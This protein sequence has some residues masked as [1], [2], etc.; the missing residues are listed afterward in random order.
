MKIAGDAFA[1]VL[2]DRYLRKDLFPLQLHV[3]PVVPD[4]GYEEINDN[5][6]YDQR[7]E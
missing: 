5:D 1:L 7:Y 4:D 2:P 6:P 3:P